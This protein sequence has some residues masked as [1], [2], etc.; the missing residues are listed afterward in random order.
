MSV[1]QLLSGSLNVNEPQAQPTGMVAISLG[2]AI[3]VVQFPIGLPDPGSFKGK[4]WDVKGAGRD[5]E[6][7]EIDCN[8][9]NW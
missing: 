2:F 9:T 1:T 6:V 4:R 8:Q 7:I 3:R 5:S